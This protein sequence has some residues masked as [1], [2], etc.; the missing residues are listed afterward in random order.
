[1]DWTKCLRKKSPKFPCRKGL[2]EVGF[3]PPK[4]Y[5]SADALQLGLS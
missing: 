3:L 2:R 1:V 5:A 4:K